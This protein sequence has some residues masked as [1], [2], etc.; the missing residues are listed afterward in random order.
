MPTKLSPRTVYMVIRTLDPFCFAVAFTTS[1]IYRFRFAGL[2]PLQLTL[3]GTALE[4]SVFLLEI[5]TGVVADVYS[6]RLS[7][8]TGYALIGLG[9]MCEGL[10]PLFGTIVLAQVL[11]GTG[12]TFTSGALD[13][14]LASEL[15]EERL[16]QV[17][18]RA[19]Q[20]SQA[21]A[22][23]GIVI[24]VAIASFR[25]NWP[26]L[27]GGAGLMLLALFLRLFMPET[28]FQPAPKTKR[29]TWGKMGNALGKGLMEIRNRPLLITIMGISIAYGLYSEAVDRLWQPH[30]LDNFT[31]PELGGFDAIYW[32]GAISAATMLLTIVVTE[33]L[34]RRVGDLGHHTA[35]RLL[36]TLNAI[37][38]ISLIIFGLSTRF[39]LALAAY[40]AVAVARQSSWPIFATWINRGI[41]ADVRATVLSTISQMDSLGQVVGGPMVGAVANRWGLRAAMVTASV[42]LAPALALLVRARG[43]NNVKLAIS[44]SPAD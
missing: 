36:L 40:G 16:S 27:V 13:A 18:L 17:Y 42:V 19:S 20:T 12:Y 29:R 15:G 8:V 35:V 2:D 41:V 5:P 11:W 32:F 39:D 9:L 4:I 1:A 34:R 10:L 31:L 7:V 26:F 43:Q 22:L 3:V 30:I 38:A 23:V 37:V 28:A 21:A 24:G 33:G 14:W 25:L 6:R 44:T